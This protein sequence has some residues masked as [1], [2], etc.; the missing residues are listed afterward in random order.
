MGKAA[1]FTAPIFLPQGVAAEARDCFGV[2][3]A[4]ALAMTK[5]SDSRPRS[6]ALALRHEVAADVSLARGL[7]AKGCFAFR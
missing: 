7:A 6:T 3:A 1:A 2:A 4:T 5:R